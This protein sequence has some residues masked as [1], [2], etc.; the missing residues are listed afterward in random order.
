M[1]GVTQ[2]SHLAFSF[3]HSFR[4][5][6]VFFNSAFKPP[7]PQSNGKV[8]QLKQGPS[9]IMLQ[10]KESL[11]DVLHVLRSQAKKSPFRMEPT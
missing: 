3:L 10:G 7:V 4:F 9:A 11:I 6:L 2:A 8:V 1:L 5:F